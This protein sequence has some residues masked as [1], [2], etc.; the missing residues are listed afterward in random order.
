M[1]RQS[2]FP[3][4]QS[5]FPPS[6]FLILGVLSIAASI[7]FVVRAVAV[8]A[9]AD[10]IWSAVIFGTFGFFWLAAYWSARRHPIN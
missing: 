9:T 6:G 2:S 1:D 3:P 7:V 4:S 8:E 10:R 5:S